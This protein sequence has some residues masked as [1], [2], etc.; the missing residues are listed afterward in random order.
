MRQ[1]PRVNPC[2]PSEPCRGGSYNRIVAC[3]MP[4]KPEP[5]EIPLG[6]SQRRMMISIAVL[7]AI[8]AVAMLNRQTL[9]AHYYA[10]RLT[11]S[12]DSVV[13]AYYFPRLCA[14]GDAAVGAAARLLANQDAGLRIVAVGVLHHARSDRARTLLLKALD[15]PD[16]EVRDLAVLG[17]AFFHDLRATEPLM[18]MLSTPAEH[19]ALEAAVALERIGGNQAVDALINAARTHPMIDVRAQSID[20]LGRL[21]AV[22][23]IDPLI[24]LLVDET[25]VGFEAA[26]DRAARRALERA[27]LELNRRGIT[28][29]PVSSQPPQFRTIADVADQALRRIT[30]ES[31]DFRSTDPPDRKQNAIQLWRLWARQRRQA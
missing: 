16:E 2:D 20:S 12:S 13:H 19:P 24:D 5:E 18:K 22:D 3:R 29:R 10:I 15:D 31:F 21:G 9:R 30:R 26:S 4:V 14:M 28:S 8:W 11:H 17:L 7:V 1:S 27:G 25:P 23:A 6:R